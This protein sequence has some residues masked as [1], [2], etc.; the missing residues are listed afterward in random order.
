MNLWPRPS[1]LHIAS[2][3]LVQFSTVTSYRSNITP[4]RHTL[5]T[6]RN[7]NF[8]RN[9]GFKFFTLVLDGEREQAERALF[10]FVRSG[11]DW[12]RLRPSLTRTNNC[13]SESTSVRDDSST[14][15]TAR[16]YN[17]A[18]GAGPS[19]AT[20]KILALSKYHR[21]KWCASLYTSDL[22]RHLFDQKH[23]SVTGVHSNIYSIS[24]VGI[25]QFIFRTTGSLQPLITG[26]A[27]LHFTIYF[28]WLK[29][30]CRDLGD[31]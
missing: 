28:I 3:I 12:R 27:W 26:S 24:T 5:Y 20:L 9:N 13:T 15:A 30:D 7:Y 14:R 29:N 21:S 2:T 18:H 6:P 1:P 31:Y 25:A 10:W 16:L 23:S 4:R 8:N 22:G 11:R 17:R 19:F